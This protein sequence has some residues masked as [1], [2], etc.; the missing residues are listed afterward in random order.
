MVRRTKGGA[1]RTRA[2]GDSLGIGKAS[3]QGLGET[4]VV[5]A[6]SVRQYGPTHTFSGHA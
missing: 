5:K 2:T 4:S 1:K 3:I 6:Y